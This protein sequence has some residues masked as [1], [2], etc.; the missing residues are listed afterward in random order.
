L[1]SNPSKERQT[2]LPYVHNFRRLPPLLRGTSI[3]GLLFPLGSLALLGPMLVTTL[4]YFPR[5]PADFDRVLG[6]ALNLGLLGWACSA[7]VNTYSV[8]FRQSDRGPFPL[9][10]WQ[11]QVRA[12]ALVA[13]LPLCA[14]VLAIA[15]PSASPASFFVA[16]IT[17]LAA[18][19]VP[20]AYFSLIDGAASSRPLRMPRTP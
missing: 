15:L 14:L 3:L 9:S 10:S 11:S 5:L 6:I 20:V 2:V 1:A 13:A 8:R 18:V 7:V 16:G 17:L 12:L 19:A 4:P